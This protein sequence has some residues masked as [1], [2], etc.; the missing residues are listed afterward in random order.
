M[1]IRHLAC[2][3][4][5]STACSFSLR[6]QEHLS[7]SMLDDSL[8]SIQ[9]KIQKTDNDSVRQSLNTLF[10]TTLKTAIE[11]PGSFTY[12]FDSLKKLAKMTSP[13][14]KFRIYNWN[15]PVTNGSNLYF[16]FLQVPDKSSK[17]T[18]RI[19]ELSDR[20]D[21][22]PDPEHSALNAGCWYGAL[23]FKI[24]QESSQTGMIYTLLG[25][26]STTLSEMKKI[27]E[28]L[29]FDDKNL[30]HFGKKIFNKYKDGENRRV[31]FKYSPV[32]TMVL[33]YE[34]QFLSKGKKWNASNRTFE[35]SRSKASMIVCDRLVTLETSEGKGQVLV[36]AGD[37][38]DGFIFENDRWNFVESV[39]ARNR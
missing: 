16:C 29:T 4:V 39:D 23:Y 6:S 15:L 1:L 26:E 7:L 32:A 17:H 35:E 30:P 36:P 12:P 5:F 38:Y 31:I 20:S 11:L 28:I 3:L 33:R 13:D 9:R 25:W 19:I 24:I 22:I 34:E 14:K 27:I 2:F 10:R 37:V 18:F 8:S 21:S